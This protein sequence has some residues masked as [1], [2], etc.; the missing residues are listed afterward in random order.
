[1]F[2]GSRKIDRQQLKNALFHVIGGCATIHALSKNDC[3]LFEA[4]LDRDV[5]VDVEPSG[6]DVGCLR[7]DTTQRE[8]SVISAILSDEILWTH[9]AN[10]VATA[11]PH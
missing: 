6:I 1:M 9:L 5:L 2:S 4:K 7:D 10:E 11:H 3:P 8:Q